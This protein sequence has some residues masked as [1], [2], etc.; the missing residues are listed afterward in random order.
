MLLQEFVVSGTQ[1]FLEHPLAEFQ[2]PIEGAKPGYLFVISSGNQLYS[3]TGNALFDWIRYARDHFRFG[4]LMDC[5]NPDNFTIAK[6][7]CAKNKIKFLVETP[8]PKM[9]APNPGVARIA[10]HLASGE[11]PFVEIVSWANASTNLDVVSSAPITTMVIFTPYTQPHWTIGD[12]A[13]HF[14]LD[15]V[16]KHVLKKSRCHGLRVTFGTNQHSA[17]I[18]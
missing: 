11:W 12:S 8:A 1:G 10:R 7:F 17:G 13:S 2:P 15:P 14:L 6:T 16:F 9:G 5:A 4:I 18:S 3:G